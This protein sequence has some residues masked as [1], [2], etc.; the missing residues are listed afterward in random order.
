[1]ILKYI[2]FIYLSYYNNQFVEDKSICVSLS[3]KESILVPVVV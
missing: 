3:P 1:M 2:A